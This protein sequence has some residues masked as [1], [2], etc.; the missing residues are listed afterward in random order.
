MIMHD[1]D[2]LLQNRGATCVSARA[3]LSA[4]KSPR[5]GE[6]RCPEHLP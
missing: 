1:A 4:A 2:W 5:A 6:P 3:A